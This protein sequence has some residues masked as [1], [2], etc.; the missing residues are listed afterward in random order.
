VSRSDIIVTGNGDRDSSA[1]V[2]LIPG[3]P[4]AQGVEA[5]AA[6]AKRPSPWYWI[7]AGG[8]A[9]VLLYYSLR[10]VEWGRVWR[11]MLGARWQ[12]L[13]AG[14]SI[15]VINFFVRSI[16]WRVLLNARGHFRVG[17]VFWAT[18][19]GYMG[20]SFLPARAGEVVRSFI[21]SDQSALSRTYVLTTALTERLMDA[22]A[23]VLCGSVVLL[24]VSPKPAWM[25][26]V[27]RTTAVI[28]ALGA[29][30]V[31]V[32]PHAEGLIQKL[33]QRMPLPGAIRD[34]L[35]GFAGQILL[36]LRA[37]H[38]AGR[39]LSFTLLTALIW[40]GDAVANIVASRAFD[41]HMTFPVAL[42]LLAG[43]GLGSAL[44]ATPGYVGIYQFAAVTILP[45]FG[46]DRNA[47]LAFIIVAQAV[48]YA[49]V[50][51]LGLLGLYRIRRGKTQARTENQSELRSDGQARRLIPPG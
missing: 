51:V 32:L 19:V 43:M 2:R 15:T 4:E 45:P 44:P 29:L 42:L 40:A 49:V 35:L 25:D 14:T 6:N 9:A 22:I 34:R 18:M 8:L 3:A 47:A 20:N 50:L 33:L 36:G 16:R 7:L 23:L 26:Q 31:A 46:I 28:A 11:I 37:F 24:Q 5:A 30:A 1:E 48:G 21:I 12:Y 10:G 41:I 17:T 38:H 39:L 13:A 27:G